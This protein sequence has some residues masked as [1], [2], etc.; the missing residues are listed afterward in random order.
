M[1][2]SAD[3]ISGS[4]MDFNETLANVNC[5]GSGASIEFRTI[6]DLRHFPN[7]RLTQDSG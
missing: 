3:L 6:L 2:H 1:W 5:G 7:K 4:V